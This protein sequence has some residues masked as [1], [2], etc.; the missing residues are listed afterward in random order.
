MPEDRIYSQSEFPA[1]LKWQA[2][3]FMRTEWPY[4]FEEDDKFLTET[5]PPELNPVHFVV[6]QGDMLISYAALVRTTL[7][8]AGYIYQAYDKFQD[9]A[10]LD[11]REYWI[12]DYSGLG[13]IR[14]IRKPKRPTLYV[15][16]LVDGEYEIQLLRGNQPIVSVTFPGLNLTAEQVLTA[17]R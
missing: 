15:C 2:L 14:H 6:V 12:A 4:I 10:A 9:Y 3:A 13:G 7:K 8:H 1:V 17:D 11:I 16:T 5:Y